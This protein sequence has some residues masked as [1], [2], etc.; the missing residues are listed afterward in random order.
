MKP[1]TKP[2]FETA[3]ADDD[4]GEQARPVRGIPLQDPDAAAQFGLKPHE[5]EREVKSVLIGG[6]LMA[7]AATGAAVGV[8]VAGPVGVL[9]GSTLGAVVGAVGAVAAGAMVNPDSTN[10]ADTAPIATARLPFK[11]SAAGAGPTQPTAQVHQVIAAPAS[12]FG[13]P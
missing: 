2:P 1:F 4:L 11:S 12:D 7:G 9:V 6:G 5:G 8:A 13:T 3:P 10:D